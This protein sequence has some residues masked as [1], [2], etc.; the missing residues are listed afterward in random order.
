MLYI[1]TF[2]SFPFTAIKYLLS[3]LVLSLCFL[4]C[5]PK[6]LPTFSFV[7]FS[8]CFNISQVRNVSTLAE[9]A[10]YVATVDKYSDVLKSILEWVARNSDQAGD[11]KMENAD[12]ILHA[13]LEDDKEQVH[14]KKG[15]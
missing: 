2:Y 9:T 6:S 13:S 5:V 10:I 7:I 4:C 1:Q 3:V 11:I 15:N 12:C 14:N 8:N